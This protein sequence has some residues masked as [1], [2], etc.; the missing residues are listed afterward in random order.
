MRR[1]SI[2]RFTFAVFWIASFSCA[3]FAQTLTPANLGGN[4]A[5]GKAL[6][7]ERSDSLIMFR[8][9]AESLSKGD[10]E[11]GG[12]LFYAAQIRAAIDLEAY[13]PIGTG[14]SS[15]EVLIGALRFQLGQGINPL[16]FRDRDLFARIVARLSNWN[17]V[18][19]P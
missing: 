1:T 8:A 19:D 11:R 6:D 2:I 7:D 3:C 15:P 10:L 16:T 5:D 4:N 18:F 14:G 9:A 17:A 13:K 12:Y